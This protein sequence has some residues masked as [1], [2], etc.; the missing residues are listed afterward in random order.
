MQLLTPVK[1]VL[2]VVITSAAGAADP[3][4]PNNQSSNRL[5]TPSSISNRSDRQLQACGSG[6]AGVESTVTH[7]CSLCPEGYSAGLCYGGCCEPCLTGHSCN[8]WFNRTCG[9]RATCPGSSGYPECC[10]ACPAGC[11]S[12]SYNGNEGLFCD[13]C[14]QGYF[15]AGRSNYQLC[16]PCPSGYSYFPEGT[17]PYGHGRNT[18][19]YCCELCSDSW[20]YCQRC[21]GSG[22]CSECKPGYTLELP[23]G[24]TSWRNSTCEPC[25]NNCISCGGVAH[26]SECEDGYALVYK[27]YDDS[28]RRRGS[29]FSCQACS[30]T[31]CSDLRSSK[32]VQSHNFTPCEA[33]DAVCENLNCAWSETD[34]QCQAA[35]DPDCTAG[36][37][38]SDEPNVCEA[39]NCTHASRAACDACVGCEWGERRPLSSRRNLSTAPECEAGC[40]PICPDGQWCSQPDTCKA[41]KTGGEACTSHAECCGIAATGLCYG[42]CQIVCDPGCQAGYW[43][44]QLNFCES[45]AGCLFFG[46]CLPP[47]QITQDNCTLLGGSWSQATTA[48][49]TLIT[50]APR[51][52]ITTTVNKCYELL[53]DCSWYLGCLRDNHEQCPAEESY[54]EQYG[55]LA[56]EKFDEALPS[57]T[58]YGKEWV[59]DVRLCLQLAIY[60]FLSQGG[61]SPTCSTIRSAAFDS[62]P[63]CYLSPQSTAGSTSVCGLTWADKG[64]LLQI[65]IPLLVQTW[66]SSIPQIAQTV[67]GCVEAYGRVHGGKL[68]EIVTEPDFPLEKITFTVMA[69]SICKM[70]GFV[71][72]YGVGMM[73][74]CRIVNMRIPGDAVPKPAGMHGPPRLLAA[75]PITQLVNI[76]YE[77]LVDG[78]PEETIAALNRDEDFAA[79]VSASLNVTVAVVNSSIY[80]IT[81]H[82][83]SGLGFLPMDTFLETLLSIDS[84]TAPE[85][86]GASTTNTPPPDK[87][88]ASTSNAT[89]TKACGAMYLAL[90]LMTAMRV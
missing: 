19:N 75:S 18:E 34:F 29:M 45:C 40:D 21:L 55:N 37:R 72:V 58:Q 83:A 7:G 56:C 28:S 64:K 36:Q 13:E 82:E 62:H 31:T 77:V 44:S 49:T 80:N 61:T 22:Y 78:A 90:V 5:L 79:L 2:C 26:C 76:E 57:F 3:G 67:T 81:H 4:W 20:P 59:R 42:T 63:G 15:R 10:E 16:L 38:C 52:S 43:C 6:G 46:L 48:T 86:R 53:G 65:V 1:L 11:E 60:D 85:A 87:T 23:T 25:S 41:C 89:Y 39:C 69:A 8:G 74:A 24:Q 47:E 66:S 84:S 51:V 88:K 14:I 54:A 17:C 32:H 30:D 68:I 12:C 9:S 70:L 73:W 35:C 71:P 50:A 33:A 27:G